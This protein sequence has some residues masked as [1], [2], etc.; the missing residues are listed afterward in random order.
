[1]CYHLLLP[2]TPK[3]ASPRNQPYRKSPRINKNH[4][5]SLET[6]SIQS[7]S[8]RWSELNEDVK[9]EEIPYSPQPVETTDTR[10]L[11]NW[12]TPNEPIIQTTKAQPKRTQR[13]VKEIN[14]ECVEIITHINR[15]PDIKDEIIPDI[16]SI[17]TK[18]NRQQA[19]QTV[20]RLYKIRDLL[21]QT[22]RGIITYGAAYNEWV[23]YNQRC[24]SMNHFA[25]ET[26]C[27]HCMATASRLDDKFY[28]PITSN[29]TMQ[30]AATL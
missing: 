16:P 6:Q 3:M 12:L 28:E 14:T 4:A 15:W 21:D 13:M 7:S 18:Q 22:F 1:M 27:S 25:A 26:Y 2:T 23:A 17:N 20:T 9:W 30:K 24:I 19:Y 5:K 10:P 29:I 8:T 11:D